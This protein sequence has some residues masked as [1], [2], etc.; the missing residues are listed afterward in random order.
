MEKFGSGIWGKHPGYATLK[1]TNILHYNK[2]LQEIYRITMYADVTFRCRWNDFK[3]T[4]LKLT[5]K[6]PRSQKKITRI[7]IIA[8]DTKREIINQLQDIK[9]AIINWP[10]GSGSL[11]YIKDSTKFQKKVQWFGNIFF[12][13]PQKC[14]G[15]IRIRF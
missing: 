4:V 2:M 9:T 5:Y 6:R 1:H 11:V 13:G 3:M 10:S 8:D 7:F 15:R 14:P 12:R